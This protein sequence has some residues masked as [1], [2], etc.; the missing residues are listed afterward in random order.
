MCINITNAGI[1]QLKHEQVDVS[2]FIFVKSIYIEG[3]HNGLKRSSFFSPTQTHF[4][5][6]EEKRPIHIRKIILELHFLNQKCR[7]QLHDN[8]ISKK[9]I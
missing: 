2:I 9:G 1:F 7:L 4:D 6:F 3:K 5:L 8:V